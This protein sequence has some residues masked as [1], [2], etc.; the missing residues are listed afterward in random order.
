[1]RD[2]WPTRA[3]SDALRASSARARRA[4]CTHVSSSPLNT[5]SAAG[6]SACARRSA[7]SVRMVA[8][9]WCGS[10]AWRRA[11]SASRSPSSCG[12]ASNVKGSSSSQ[13]AGVALL[14][15]VRSRRRQRGCAQVPSTAVAWAARNRWTSRMMESG[16]RGAE[17]GRGPVVGSSTRSSAAPVQPRAKG[18]V[19]AGRA[20]GLGRAE[21][22]VRR[23]RRGKMRK[24]MQRRANL[25][26]R[27]NNAM[28]RHEIK[29]KY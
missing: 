10:A 25:S 15:A 17:G 12:E 9:K 19:K 24:N 29:K 8:E 7:S 28:P 22:R 11:G 5:H 26:E 3:G 27:C 23:M 4:G 1:M 13:P 2:T 16:E 21:Q 6:L 18:A 20:R 14:P